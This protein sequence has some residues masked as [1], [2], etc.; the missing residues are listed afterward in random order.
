MIA[1]RVRAT[2][3]SARRG[4]RSASHL[5][6]AL[7]AAVL[8]A[9]A[10]DNATALPAVGISD[11]KASTFADARLAEL[12]VRYV[13]LVAPYNAVWTEPAR[14]DAWLGAARAAGVEAH[15]ALE[16]RRGDRCPEQPCELPSVET[17]LS[18]FDAF[19]ARYPDVRVF[20]P[21]NEANHSSQPTARNPQRAAAYYEGVRDR[22]PGCQIVAADLLDI[23]NMIAW[24]TTFRAQLHSTPDIWGLH[25]YGDVNDGTTAATDRL[26]A[27]VPGAVWLTETGGVV[28]FRDRAGHVVR[29]Y[30]EGRARDAVERVFALLERSGERIQRAYLYHWQAGQSFERFDA[31]LIRP[32][33]TPRPA[34]G[35]LRREL[36]P[37]LAVAIPTPAGPPDVDVRP[38]GGTVAT[39]T[40]RLAARLRLDRRVQRLARRQLRLVVTCLTGGARCRGT[41]EIR[42][43]ARQRRWSGRFDV[44]PGKRVGLALASGCACGPTP[45]RLR[46]LTA[47]AR[48]QGSASTVRRSVQ[49]V[50]SQRR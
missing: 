35:V 10:A 15:V 39:G 36:R 45:R 33:G 31:G 49:L 3:R 42:H 28:F 26:L 9:L 11:N 34:F 47:V 18:A 22:C 4:R 32:D 41:L 30:D 46:R 40:N 8:A 1:R 2:A 43:V 50:A 17:Y 19:R 20:T 13:R 38:A 12:G 24:L 25:N 27:A 29:A 23:E 21:W 44:R 6:A 14:L 16:H 5:A 48:L 7:T 37:D